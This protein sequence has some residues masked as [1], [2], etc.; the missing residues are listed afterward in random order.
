LQW[1]EPEPMRLL[2]LLPKVFTWLEWLASNPIEQIKSNYI[3]TADPAN[4]QAAAQ[5]LK[6]NRQQIASRAVQRFREMQH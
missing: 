3:A 6:D 2:G 5:V 4:F 1:A